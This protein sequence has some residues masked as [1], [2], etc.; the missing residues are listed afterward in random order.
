LYLDRSV[1]E[2]ESKS[3]TAPSGAPW[4]ATILVI[5]LVAFLF[6][7]LPL[8][9]KFYWVGFGICPQ[10]A[11]HS[12][13]L[14]ETMLPG[15]EALRAAVP[16]LSV[17]APDQGTKLPV[18]ARMYGMFAGF[19]LTWLYSFA[20]GRGRAASMPGAIILLT[21]VCFI[22]IMGFDG[23]NAT[24]FD[25]NN[26]GLP[27]PYLYAPHLEL[28][29]LTGWLCGIAIAGIVLPVVNYCLWRNAE[30]RA[31]FERWR[32]ILPLLFVGGVIF[33]LMTTGSGLFFYPLAVLAP[34]G[35]LA[36]LAALNVVLVLTLGKQ[37][38]VAANWREA[39]NPVT[40]ALFLALLE[41]SAL[42]VVRWLTFG[43]GEIGSF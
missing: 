34:V 43:V 5:G 37:E 1:L 8:L 33:V 21:Y 10:R 41:L 9:D 27:I 13:F 6:F 29:F 2:P 3:L 38:R 12:Y 30:P 7:P 24:L 39:M 18:E 31:L 4:G 14:G 11:G 42:S 17:V 15:E 40:L 20:V 22:S 25:L 16:F 32:E 28:R 23:I 36:T 35:I 19:L 26:A